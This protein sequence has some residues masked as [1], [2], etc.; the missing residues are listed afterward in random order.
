MITR[1]KNYMQE[2]GL[3]PADMLRTVLFEHRIQ[4][5]RFRRLRAAYNNKGEILK[6]TR[7]DGLPNNRLPHAYAH[8]ITTI[9]TG[10]LIGQPVEYS[11]TGDNPTL[12]LIQDAFR[13]GS[14]SA[15]NTQIARD[16]SIYGKGIEYIHVD[17]D[18]ELLPHT[19][20]ISPENAFVVY[21]DTYDQEPLFGVYYVPKKRA[22][23]TDD[24]WRVWVMT[25]KVIVEYS[26]ASPDS[27]PHRLNDGVPHYFGGVPLVEYW[28]NENEEGDFENVLE[29]INA[30]DLLESDRV[31]DKEQF[32]D[33]LLVLTGAVLE[34]DAEGR[35]PMQQLK[36]DHALQLPDTQSRVEYLSSAL[37]ENGVEILRAAL[38]EDIHK[39]SLVPDL[40]DRNFAANASGVAMR[41]KLLGFEQLIRV[42]EQWFTEGLRTRLKLFANFLRTRSG[43]RELDVSDISITFTHALPANLAENATIAQSAMNSGTASLETAVKMLHQGESWTAEE[44]AAEVQRIMDQRAEEARGM[45]AEDFKT[46]DSVE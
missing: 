41:Y 43:A 21:N 39:L 36:E 32:V 26:A 24:G 31:N 10:Y 28:N 27:I 35:K 6:R 34:T 2:N 5:E 17:I 14:E 13:R 15:E 44:I 19:T 30:Y 3:P 40:S 11:T 16:Q 22:D 45:L 42:K 8:Y 46:A 20:A 18:N 12:Q 9:A 38:I 37:D 1:S 23:G 25:D 29:L 33:K 4:A 7:R